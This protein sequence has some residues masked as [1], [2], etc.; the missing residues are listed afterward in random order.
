MTET[1][2]NRLADELSKLN[3][4]EFNAFIKEVEQKHEERHREQL[5]DAFNAFNESWE[6]M[7]E[8][9]YYPVIPLA[10]GEEK[11][12]LDLIIWREVK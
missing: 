4:D 12:S 11:I 1:R 3:K 7:E 9:G 10:N 8:L 2:F 6:R 5:R